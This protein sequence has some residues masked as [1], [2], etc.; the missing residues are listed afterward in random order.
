MGIMKNVSP[1]TDAEAQLGKN[2]ARAKRDAEEQRRK[3]RTLAKQQQAAEKIASAAVQMA[4]GVTEAAT[5]RDQLSTAAQEI[6]AGA[7]QSSSASQESLAAMTQI[8]TRITRQSEM[9]ELSLTR[10]AELQNVVDRVGGDVE[11]LIKNVGRASQRQSASVSMVNELGEQA[12]KINEAVKQVMR[13][14]DQTNLLALNAAIEAGRAGKHGK[15]FAV[16]ADTVRTLAEISERNAADIAKQIETI[17]SKTMTI[18]ES[19][20]QSANTALEE[21]E[22]GKTITSQLDDIKSNMGQV[23]DGAQSLRRAASEMNTAARDAQKGSEAIAAAAEEQASA[24]EEVVKTLEQQGQALSGAEEASSGLEIL[25]DE[26]K[27]STDIAKSSEEVAASAEELSAS[28]EEINRSSTEIM[29]AIGQ[30]SRGAEQASTAVEQAVAGINQIESSTNVANEESARGLEL[31]EAVSALL[32][33]NK[34]LVGEMVSGINTALEA[35]KANLVEINEV[36]AMARQIDKVGEAIGTVSVKIAMLAVNGAVEAARAGEYGK[37]FAVVS[38]DIQ[39]LADDAAENVDQIKDLV[40]AIQDQAQKV[41]MD[42]AEVASASEAEVE[43]ATQSSADLDVI[44][45]G[46]RE[47]LDGNREIQAGAVEVAA[48]VVQA[49]RGMEQIAA[50]NEQA[51]NNATEASSASRQQAQGAEELASAIEEIASIADE[52]QVG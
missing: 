27:N 48:A 5:A 6:A 40:K 4:R 10:S 52:L 30:I 8:A 1:A 35:G 3:A 29:T 28:V 51:A 25:A 49:K 9:A 32:S 37:G 26:L 36:E 39:S 17:Q 46:A 41:R 15:G 33:E 7:E 2:D 21:V 45:A 16:V 23:A 11:S 38:G 24:V 44:E 50:A 43:K 42:L 13:I 19:V 22:K 18:S 47:V 34:T 14:A 31:C 12:S 20:Q